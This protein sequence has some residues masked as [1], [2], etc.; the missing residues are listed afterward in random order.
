MKLYKHQE[1]FINSNPNRALLVWETGTGKTIAAC[2]WLAKRSGKKALVIC[3]RGIVAKWARDLKE[4]G[5]T[6][7]ITTRD[8]M[9]KTNLN[10]YGAIVVDEAQDFASPLFDKSRSARTTKLYTYVRNH[11]GSHILL[12]TATPV[13][14]TPW[15]IHTLAA[16]LSHFWPIKDFR[17]K[18]FHL[19]DRYGR[20]HYEKNVGWQK[21]IR[22]YVEEIADIVL[23]RDCADVPLQHH[24]TRKITWSVHQQKKLTSQYL[25]PIAEWHARHR[26]ENGLEKLEVVKKI[27]SGYRKVI[28][29]CYYREQLDYWMVKLADERRV[30][31]LHGDTKNPDEVI[32]EARE[33]DDCIFLVQASMGAGFDAA[34]FSVVIFASMSFRYVDHV[35]M[36]GRVKRINNLH[37][38]LFIYLIGGKCDRAVYNAIQAG[39]DFDVH[40]DIHDNFARS[41]E[42]KDEEGT[43]RNTESVTVV[44]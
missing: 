29:V 9:K 33:A 28:V 4:W 7:D 22:P 10:N 12:L 15:N 43:E 27:A 41:T 19:T 32:E 2:A 6:A 24:Q 8:Q 38:N 26:A 5:A 21:A 17:N 3:P 31:A 18:F 37:E 16:F 14:S 44:S 20:M 36:K 34:E 42:N 40:N 11:P 25:E 23:M 35:Q 1:R 30:L 13:R 39:R